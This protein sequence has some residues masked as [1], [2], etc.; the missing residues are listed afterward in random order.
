MY[1]TNLH[2]IRTSA[3]YVQ[4]AAN[5][6]LNV[7]YRAVQGDCVWMQLHWSL[8]M[9]TLSP[10]SPGGPGGPPGPGRPTGP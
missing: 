3:R 1:F 6:E 5:R 9:L 10:S 8:R 7:L 4:E 2:L